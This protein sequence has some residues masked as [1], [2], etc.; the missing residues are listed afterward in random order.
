MPTIMRNKDK[1]RPLIPIVFVA[2]I[3]LYASRNAMSTGI[4]T[5]RITRIVM[6]SASSLETRKDCQKMG[7]A[8]SCSSSASN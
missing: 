3:R 8:R 5:I 2:R 4:N 1:T 7:N 6:E